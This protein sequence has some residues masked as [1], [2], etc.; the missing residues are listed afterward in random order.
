VGLRAGLD[1]CGKSRAPLGFDPRTA[2]LVGSR[3]TDYATRPTYTN[4]Y[5][6]KSLVFGMLVPLPRYVSL[7]DFLSVV[8]LEISSVF[9]SN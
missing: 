1:R 3:Y 8:T 7:L 4:I 2:Q 5:V 9:N 6:L